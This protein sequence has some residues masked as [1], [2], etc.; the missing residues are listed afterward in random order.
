MNRNGVIEIISFEQAE[1]TTQEQA[2]T[3]NRFWYPGSFLQK[4]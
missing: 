1:G 4:G 2:A 3:G